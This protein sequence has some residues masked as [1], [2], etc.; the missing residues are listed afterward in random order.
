LEAQAVDSDVRGCAQ[1]QGSSAREQEKPP[2][3]TSLRSDR[4]EGA[5][6]VNG[7]ILPP[8][9][10]HRL[11]GMR[12][13]QPRAWMARSYRCH[14]PSSW[15]A[16]YSPATS[17]STSPSTRHLLGRRP[18]AVLRA[19]LSWTPL[20]SLCCAPPSPRCGD[21]DAVPSFP[22]CARRLR[23]PG[24][25]APPPSLRWLRCECIP[26]FAY[27]PTQ[28]GRPRPAT[29]CDAALTQH[30]FADNARSAY[31]PRMTLV[32]PA[33]GPPYDACGPRG[34]V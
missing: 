18:P 24:V 15:D 33:H 6:S 14:S 7:N 28:Q 29:L 16:I 5:A 4:L 21:A 1:D 3:T 12:K 20:S 19:L 32:L 13:W 23:R 17:L 26:C 31:G 34:P 10:T 25:S 27:S 9:N 8:L 11:L 2:P 30:R 22:P